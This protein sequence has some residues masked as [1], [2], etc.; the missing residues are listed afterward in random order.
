MQ[1][2]FCGCVEFDIFLPAL[3]VWTSIC[4][5]QTTHDLFDNR[6][7]PSRNQW[8]AAALQWSERIM[9][10]IDNVFGGETRKV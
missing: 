4:H 9:R 10:K 6:S 7:T 8:F 3:A 2:S 5:P 1:S